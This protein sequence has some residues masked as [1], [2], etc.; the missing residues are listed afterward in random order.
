VANSI[1][2]D[3]N[4]AIAELARQAGRIASAIYPPDS[5]GGEDETDTHVTSLAEA[6]MGVT[7]ALVMISASNDNIAEGLMEIAAAIKGNATK[8][9]AE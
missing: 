9:C 5:T 4:K 2:P 3:H 8:G 6:I 7:K 1:I